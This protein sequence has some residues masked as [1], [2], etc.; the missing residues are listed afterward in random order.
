MKLDFAI[1]AMGADLLLPPGSSN[2]AVAKQ[3]CF[4]AAV[5]GRKVERGQLFFAVKGERVDGFAYCAQ[6]ARAGAAAVVVTRDRG[7][8]TGVGAVPVLAVDDPVMAL[9]KLAHAVRNT[10]QGVVIGVTGSNGKTTTKELIAAA[11]SPHGKVLRS[12]GNL[13]TEIGLPQ[14]ILSARGDEAFW[15]LEMAMRGPGEIE[16]L[17]RIACPHV[18]VVTNVGA[19]HLGRL[20]SLQAIARAKGEIYKTLAPGGTA[21]VPGNEAML[22]EDLASVPT[23]R[24]VRFGAGSF[25]QFGRGA[26]FSPGVRLLEYVPEAGGQ[27]L[28]R[29]SVGEY[30]AVLRLPL[31]GPHNAINACAALSVVWALGLPIAPSAAALANVALPPHRSNARSVGGRLVIDDCY[32]ANPASM[33]AAL[34]TLA[35]SLS[36][37]GRAFAILGDMLELG[38]DER[39]LHEALGAEAVKKG[40][41]GLAGVGKLGRLIAAGARKAGLSRSRAMA[42]DDAAEAARI[43]AGL[44][45]P[46]DAILIKASRG[47]RLEVA[48]DAVCAILG[49]SAKKSKKSVKTPKRKAKAPIKVI[50]KPRRKVVKRVSTQARKRK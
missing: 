42:T 16:T 1:K 15:V 21:V 7:R 27:S 18:A 2:K 9:G 19:A 5:D 45:A 39:A 48:V 38:P 24:I 29:V 14:A 22:G 32:N 30:P 6:A 28:I 36:A 23:G 35:G 47:M 20:G 10:Y 41:F 46:G 26:G 4:G 33:S 44:S 40:V 43:V 34:T 31:A 37:T 3:T 12:S 25:L 8:P 17:G 13:N 49:T 11:L 50:A